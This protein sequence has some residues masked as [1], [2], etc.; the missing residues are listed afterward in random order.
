MDSTALMTLVWVLTAGF[1]G[2]ALG[3]LGGVIWAGRDP[4][5]MDAH[6]ARDERMRRFRELQEVAEQLSDNATIP[7][8]QYAV[9]HEGTTVAPDFHAAVRTLLNCE[10]DEFIATLF[11][12]NHHLIC[13]KSGGEVHG[14]PDV[15]ASVWREQMMS[16]REK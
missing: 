6:R 3:F 5:P 9:S 16:G 13:Y 2:A 10:A 14:V 1:W 8:G 4:S 11:D 12:C 7:P 15:L